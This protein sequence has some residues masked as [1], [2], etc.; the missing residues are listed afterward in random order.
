[1][2]ASRGPISEEIK[3]QQRRSQVGSIGQL[4]Q[5]KTTVASHIHGFD[6]CDVLA[7]L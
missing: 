5:L 1:M 3:Q 6:K 7:W 2:G 4:Q